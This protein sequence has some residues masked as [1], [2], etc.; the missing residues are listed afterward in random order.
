MRA[1]RLY[2]SSVFA[3]A[4]LVSLG[5]LAG[6]TKQDEKLVKDEPKKATPVTSADLGAFNDFFPQSGGAGGLAVKLDGGGEGGRPPGVVAAAG[7]EGAADVEPGAAPAPEEKLKV[8]EAGAEPKAQRRYTF[9]VNKVDKRIV[10]IAQEQQRGGQRG[11]GM[12]L[13]INMDFTPKKVEP[14]GTHFD[15]K[16]NKVE[17]PQAGLAPAQQAQLSQALG[18]LGGM[19]GGFEISP[20]GE[21]G[22]VS[23]QSDQKM[24]NPLAEGVVQ[25][26]SQITELLVPAFPDAPIGAG[27]KW[28]RQQDV[29]EAGAKQSRKASYLLKE[30]N[31]EGGVV[32][33]DV[34]IKIPKR[35]VQARGVPP[36]TTV[37][38]D[39]KGHYTYQFRFDRLATTVKGELVI[40]QHIE[41]VDESGKKQAIDDVQIAK[42]TI[43]TPK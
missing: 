37:S 7:A 35:A 18:G 25:G 38:A 26:I 31:A 20:R 12:T 17:I 5:V 9:T 39:G 42:Q 21:V 34:E 3:L 19:N 29:S 43:E 23:M 1:P 27:A 32:E 36:G 41:A 14:K 24:Q 6:C 33:V 2:V 15:L 40:K 4:A 13:S 30:V 28:E 8:T 10:T 11:G 22:E 16:V